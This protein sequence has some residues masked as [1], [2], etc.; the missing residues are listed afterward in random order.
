MRGVEQSACELFVSPDAE[1]DSL[2][3]AHWLKQL[4]KCCPTPC[5]HES[6]PSTLT[7]PLTASAIAAGR[8]SALWPGP[9]VVQTSLPVTARAPDGEILERAGNHVADIVIRLAPPQDA[10]RMIV[11]VKRLARWERKSQAHAQATALIQRHGQ[12]Y[13]AQM[14]AFAG[15]PART[16]G[17]LALVNFPLGGGAAQVERIALAP[18]EQPKRKGGRKGGEA[19]AAAAAAGRAAAA[20]AEADAAPEPAAEEEAAAA[21]A[22]AAPAPAAEAAGGDGGAGKKRKRAAPKA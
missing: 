20:P 6:L 14:A 22:E 4:G 1:N 5:R 7:A 15:R 3:R 9:E 17:A 18:P 11:E 10:S 13:D 19:A 12:W 2:K 21:E 8:L 16:A